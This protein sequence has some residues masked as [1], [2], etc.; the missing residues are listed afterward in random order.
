MFSRETGQNQTNS[1]IVDS[2]FVQQN[3]VGSS[4]VPAG[5]FWDLLNNQVFFALSST[6]FE[7]LG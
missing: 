7:F 2:P 5:D 1:P 3:N 6:E 4:S